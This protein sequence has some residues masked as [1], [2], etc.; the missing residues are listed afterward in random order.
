MLSSNPERTEDVSARWDMRFVG[1]RTNP[2]LHEPSVGSDGV[3]VASGVDGRMNGTLRRYLGH[4][5]LEDIRRA[6]MLSHTFKSTDDIPSNLAHVLAVRPLVASAEEVYKTSLE[7]TALKD[8]DSGSWSDDD[9]AGPGDLTSPG[10]GDWT[11][12]PEDG[13]HGGEISNPGWPSENEPGEPTDPPDPP[14][15]PHPPPPPEA[16][17]IP[18]DWGHGTADGGD[19]TIPPPPPEIIDFLTNGDIVQQVFPFEVTAHDRSDGRRTMKGFVLRVA[20]DI[21]RSCPAGLVEYTADGL[22]SGPL[23]EFPLTEQSP[24]RNTILVVLVYLPLEDTGLS[25]TAVSKFRLIV[26]CQP[27]Y[28]PFDPDGTAPTN[29]LYLSNRYRML[30]HYFD[31][32]DVFPGVPTGVLPVNDDNG[33]TFQSTPIRC[34]EVSVTHDERFVYVFSKKVPAEFPPLVIWHDLD[35]GVQGAKGEGTVSQ[36]HIAGGVTQGEEPSSGSAGLPRP[37]RTMLMSCRSPG[38][39]WDYFGPNFPIWTNDTIDGEVV[40]CFGY[41]RGKPPQLKFDVTTGLWGTPYTGFL[42]ARN[43]KMTARFRDEYRPRWT[44]MCDESTI[45]TVDTPANKLVY[46]HFNDDTSSPMGGG[47]YRD[48]GSGESRYTPHTVQFLYN[49]PFYDVFSTIG[50]ADAPGGYFYPIASFTINDLTFNYATRELFLR[51]CMRAHNAVGTSYSSMLRS[52]FFVKWAGTTGTSQTVLPEIDQTGNSSTQ[53]TLSAQDWAPI[54]DTNGYTTVAG[55]TALPGSGHGD[56]QPTTDV[57]IALQAPY[58]PA[59]EDVGFPITSA[60]ALERY[61]DLLVL[62]TP[63]QPSKKFLDDPDAGTILPSHFASASTLYVRWSSTSTYATEMIPD[64]NA[65]LTKISAT[66]PSALVR[67]GEYIFALGNGPILRGSRSEWGLSWQE[68]AA[69]YQLIGSRACCEARGLLF[70]VFRDD[71]ILIEP[72]SGSIQIVDVLTRL[73]RDYWTDW[74]Y[75]TTEYDSALDALYICNPLVNAV[76]IVWMATGNLTMLDGT[77]FRSVSRMNINN[78]SRVVLVSRF[79]RFVVPRFYEAEEPLSS[80][81]MTGVYPYPAPA[82]RS[83]QFKVIDVEPHPT[84]EGAGNL[85]LDPTYGN[86]EMLRR[87]FGG[88]AQASE[89]GPDYYWLG[90]RFYGLGDHVQAVGAQFVVES[91]NP[92]TRKLAVLT[93]LQELTQDVLDYMDTGGPLYISMHPVPFGVLW[94][95]LEDS[96]GVV[97]ATQKRHVKAILVA[98]SSAQGEPPPQGCPVFMAGCVRYFDI[99]AAQPPQAGQPLW[100]WRVTGAQ[101]ARFAR[102][103]PIGV[104][105]SLWNTDSQV[106]ALNVTGQILFPYFWTFLTD[107]RFEMKEVSVRGTISPSERIW[108]SQ[109]RSTSLGDTAGTAVSPLT[110]TLGRPSRWTGGGTISAPSTEPTAPGGGFGPGP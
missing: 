34:S 101:R 22:A 12:P 69:G 26:P 38:W 96:N 63:L 72:N 24:T 53:A 93:G 76:A 55:N 35:Y 82:D 31:Y 56:R 36:T 73:V 51:E 66:G 103:S 109:L 94:G 54:K 21:F 83:Y 15:P 89:G 78:T 32:Q 84:T 41:H 67:A 40:D 64:V 100:Q 18:Y 87:D 17:D 70:A 95:G 25:A 37:N 102:I 27:W 88:L 11:L 46:A 9:L 61:K 108:P 44:R 91:W 10:D 79:G 57:F 13:G 6:P 97:S 74:S 107:P 90:S 71:A 68:L 45:L 77:G 49:Y 75:V 19:D 33:E 28:H 58:E 104:P 4:I 8:L 81:T 47:A 39:H 20:E 30:P 86:L 16:S 59:Q 43:Y 60:T 5:L 110:W 85:V 3:L 7:V 80:Y 14:D 1:W 106:A 48:S 2:G 62:M 42:L 23:V 50:N 29:D 105:F 52:S 98:P 99:M 92:T 65:Y